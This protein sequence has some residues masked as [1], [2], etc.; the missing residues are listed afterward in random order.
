MNPDRLTP[1]LCTSGR[2]RGSPPPGPPRW[3][4]SAF[5]RPSMA[6]DSARSSGRSPSLLTAAMLAPWLRRYLGAGGG[7][8]EGP[9]PGP[10]QAL[11]PNPR[12]T[13]RCP[14]T[15]RRRP[16]AAASSPRCPPGSPWHPAPPGSAPPPG[17]RRYRPGGGQGTGCQPSAHPDPHVRQAGLP[18][19]ALGRI[20]APSGH[21][22]QGG[23]PMALGRALKAP[24]GPW[25][26]CGHPAV[27]DT[28]APGG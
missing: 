12:L 7:Q 18:M 23:A 22:V 27:C 21:E 4:I 10:R 11:P 2:G 28:P 16:R 1:E 9:S 5:R 26:P 19:G 14:G 25:R 6:S 3:A 20:Q 13:W 15:R 8:A 24:S 17:S